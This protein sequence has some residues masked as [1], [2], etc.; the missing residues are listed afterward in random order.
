MARTLTV[1]QYP[2]CDTCRAA[3]KQLQAQGHELD[4]RHIKDHPPTVEEL[5]RLIPASG[6]PINK[7]FNTSGDAYRSLGLK[8]QMTKLSDEE[9]MALLASNGM[10]IKRPVVSDGHAA[11]VGFREEELERVY[12]D[13]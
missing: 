1:F 13:R 9:K 11:T 5:R 10:L 8:D 4:L 3:V 6:L 7:W 2:T 12:A